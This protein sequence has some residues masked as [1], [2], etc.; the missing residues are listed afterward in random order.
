MDISKSISKIFPNM[1]AKLCEELKNCNAVLDLGCGPN[2][3]IKDCE[4]S[5]S[6]GVELF[7]DYFIQSKTKKIHNKY[8]QA[9]IRKIEFESNS[10]DAVLCSEVI[11]H[12]TKEEGYN[13]LKKMEN[14]ASKKVIITTPNGYVSQSTYDNNPLQE[15]KSAWEVKQFEDLGFRVHGMMGWK[16]LR[17]NH[18]FIKYRPHK[19]WVILSNLSQKITYKFPSYSFQLF[20]VKELIK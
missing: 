7:D 19:L 10:F 6:V 8:I 18:G 15:H 17:G 16:K 11:E 2:S 12:L 3:P 14:W 9:D 1:K 13:L 5:F 4:I 20:A